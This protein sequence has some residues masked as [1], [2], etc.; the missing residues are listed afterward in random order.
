MN[1][2]NKNF[3]INLEYEGPYLFILYGPFL[4][5]KGRMR[6]KLK[7]ILTENKK[8]FSEIDIDQTY[9]QYYNQNYKDKFFNS[10]DINDLSEDLQQL[11]R[12]DASSEVNKIT[13]LQFENAILS[14]KSIIIETGGNYSSN[15]NWLT[16]ELEKLPFHYLTV[17]YYPIV[18]LETSLNRK[19][20][21]KSQINPP[22]EFIQ[23]SFI[24]APNLFFKKLVNE[25]DCVFVYS[26]EN[27]E[28]LIFKKE[29]NKF[30]IYE[31]DYENE[32]FKN[33]FKK[34]KL[35]NRL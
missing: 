14:N 15:N 1:F 10:S 27:E 3:Q 5:G 24:K 21:R 23:S 13:D 8:S 2:P 28:K 35:I 29:K 18:S 6:K 17:I 9:I 7:E 31:E 34:F 4:S 19:L 30:F 25:V 20:S 26:N 32:F 22:N 33:C 16:N 12:K 11:Y